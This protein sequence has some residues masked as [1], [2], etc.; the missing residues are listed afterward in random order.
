MAPPVG[1]PQ[2]PLV[3]SGVVV[4]SRPIADCATPLMEQI[5]D[6]PSSSWPR[7]ISARQG[8][9]VV[10]FIADQVPFPASVQLSVVSFPNASRT[11]RLLLFQTNRLK[12]ESS[13]VV[14]EVVRTVPT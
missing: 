10:A 5:A 11:T 1:T 6:T 2:E 13:V 9:V 3:R 12:A 4:V 8:L 7:T 14:A